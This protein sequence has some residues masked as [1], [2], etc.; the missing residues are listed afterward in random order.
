MSE[1]PHHGRSKNQDEEL[2]NS[3]PQAVH[4]MVH[5]R[6]LRR[7]PDRRHPGRQRRGKLYRWILSSRHDFTQVHYA[8]S[9]R[10]G[11]SPTLI[12]PPTEPFMRSTTPRYLPLFENRR[13]AADRPPAFAE[14]PDQ[15]VTDES[16]PQIDYGVG[17][18]HVPGRPPTKPDKQVHFQFQA[19]TNPNLFTA[20]PAINAAGDLSFTPATNV[21]G[22]AQ[23]TIVLIDDGGTAN[24]GVDTSAPQTFTIDIAKAHVWHNAANRFDVLG[25]GAVAPNDALA[26]IDFINAFGSPPVPNNG[27]ATG[28]YYDVDADKM[29]SPIDALEVINF[30]NADLNGEGEVATSPPPSVNRAQTTLCYC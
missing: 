28:P 6:R 24:G 11:L 30:I 2:M 1:V 20:L 12:G 19:N 5:R 22:S 23:I 21:S 13:G 29:V 16:G 17:H 7:S 26:V 25:E 10:E 4:G 27:V 8:Y 18:G 14:A 9:R 15:H 3:Y